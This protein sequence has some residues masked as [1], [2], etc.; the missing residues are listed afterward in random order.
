MNDRI[1]NLG[2]IY[3]PISL[4]ILVILTYTGVIQNYICGMA[5]LIMGYG[6]GLAAVFGMKF[7]K[8]KIFGMKSYVG[9]VAMFFTSLIVMILFSN[10]YN[11]GYTNSAKS[12]AIT[13]LIA[14]AVTV[15]EIFTPLGLDN[16][17]VPLS[18]AFLL[19]FSTSSL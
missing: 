17:T 3:F 4:T 6:D 14:L 10:Y 7:G 19:H 16:I 8:K 12:F 15:I 11:L 18:S 5:V 1:R 2:L 13:L 9:S